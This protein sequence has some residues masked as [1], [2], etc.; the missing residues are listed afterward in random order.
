MSNK[1]RDKN[2]SK[3][4]KKAVKNAKKAGVKMVKVEIR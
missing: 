4:L 1:K 3:Q 2:L